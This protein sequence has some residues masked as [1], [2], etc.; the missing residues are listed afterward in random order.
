MIFDKEQD[1]HRKLKVKPIADSYNSYL[2]EEKEKRD[3]SGNIYLG[4]VAVI[5]AIAFFT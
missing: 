3:W 5:L 1:V 4:C 2:I